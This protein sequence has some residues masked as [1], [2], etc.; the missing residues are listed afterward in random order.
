MTNCTADASNDCSVERLITTQLAAAWLRDE[1]PERVDR[2]AESLRVQQAALENDSDPASGTREQRV[3][4]A[5]V[6]KS[7]AEAL[8]LRSSD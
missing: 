1:P 7:L 8:I 4:A 6:L 2:F 5:A 3:A